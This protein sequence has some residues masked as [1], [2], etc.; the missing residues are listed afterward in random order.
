V[1]W[2]G[3]EIT[4][5]DTTS[6]NHVNPEPASSS[7][8]H[9]HLATFHLSHN[10]GADAETTAQKIGFVSCLSIFAPYSSY[11]F[12]F[13]LFYYLTLVFTPLFFFFFFF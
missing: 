12:F 1:S 13:T 8:R 10:A 9:T 2:V 6:R 7:A 3:F 5:R 4:D 11:L